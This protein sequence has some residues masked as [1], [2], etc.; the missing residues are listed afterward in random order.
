M[1]PAVSCLEKEQTATGIDETQL[2]IRHLLDRE[3]LLL[4]C[5]VDMILRELVPEISINE[6]GDFSILTARLKERHIDHIVPIG[7]GKHLLGSILIAQGLGI[8][9]G[10]THLGKSGIKGQFSRLLIL[11]GIGPDDLVESA[12][13]RGE[14][15]VDGSIGKSREGAVSEEDEVMAL[16][17]INMLTLKR[18]YDLLG[19]CAKAVAPEIGLH[20]VWLTIH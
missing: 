1:A 9:I 12:I 5:L 6:V 19:R 16:L 3:E 17:S 11:I 15:H 18:L 8:G 7:I 4:P 13:Y 2:G 14:E 20:L 10:I